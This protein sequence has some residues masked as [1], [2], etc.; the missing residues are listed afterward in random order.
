MYAKEPEKMSD[1]S[2]AELEEFY[3]AL[4]DGTRLRLLSLMRN[5]E[6]SVGYLSEKLDQSQ[7][8][9]SRHL[10]YL[11]SVGLVE[12]RRDG[13][14]I[15]YHIVKQ[16]N[17]FASRSLTDALAWTGNVTGEN[18]SEDVPL[19]YANAFDA[20]QPDEPRES[21]TE[22]VFEIESDGNENYSNEIE[23]FLL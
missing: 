11:R 15:F 17:G 9:I 2:L 16:T 12:T 7:P 21:D 8:K 20:Q 18:L 13:K 14:W 23:V 3:L 6:V 1:R 19:V 22:T 10:A 5:G 4:S